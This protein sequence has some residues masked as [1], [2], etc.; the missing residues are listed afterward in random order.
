LLKEIKNISNQKKKTTPERNSGMINQKRKE[1][2]EFEAA[3]VMI[4]MLF[5]GLA[6]F[7]TVAV[8]MMA[9]CLR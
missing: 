2:E 7:F 1:H 4:P 5:L 8:K 6:A 3:F 9:N